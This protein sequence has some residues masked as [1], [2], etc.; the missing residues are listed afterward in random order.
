[1]TDKNDKNR[2]I[3]TIL[4][5]KIIAIVGLILLASISLPL[6]KNMSKRYRI[7]QEIKA[8]EQEINDSGK[9][10]EALQKMISYLESDQFA[11]EQA[12]LKLGLKK[13]D[14][15]VAVIGG[16]KSGSQDPISQVMGENRL[17]GPAAVKIDSN[18]VKWWTYFF[19]H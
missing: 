5:E 4:N 18:L 7:N 14:E 8:L 19:K 2:V 12:R 9:K 11:E 3:K 17:A 6:A 1:M 10:N 16:V 13:Q 15:Q